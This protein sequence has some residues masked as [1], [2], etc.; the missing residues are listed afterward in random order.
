MK[1]HQFLVGAA[2][3]ALVLLGLAAILVD[4]RKI[5]AP[6]H[7]VA[8]QFNAGHLL[9]NLPHPLTHRFEFRNDTD[10]RLEIA[11]IKPSCGCT[12]VEAPVRAFDPGESGWLE[13]TATLH[14]SGPFTTEVVVHWSTGEKTHYTLGAF[15]Q[16]AREL[17][18]STLS[19]DLDVAEPRT[20]VLTYIDQDGQEPGPVR[21][22]AAAEALKVDVGPWKPVIAVNREYGIAAQYAANVNVELTDSLDE[23]S[24]VQFSLASLPDVRPAELVVRTPAL[25]R[26]Y[27]MKHHSR[28]PSTGPILI[29]HATEPAARTES[30]A[31]DQP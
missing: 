25:V 21:L 9:V 1:R 22:D 17:S 2:I 14:A 3:A 11:A 4:H 20:L 16:V 5:E 19:V 7:A 13:A 29:E 12:K 31:G 15:S 27:A 30:T 6:G 23:L 10:E 28:R 26:S 24:R 18:L 8:Q